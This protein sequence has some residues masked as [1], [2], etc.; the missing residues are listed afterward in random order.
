MLPD[1][2]TTWRGQMASYRGDVGQLSGCVFIDATAIAQ[3]VSGKPLG[4]SG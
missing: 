2:D 4:L 3:L 1:Y